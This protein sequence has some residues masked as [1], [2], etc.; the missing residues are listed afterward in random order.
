MVRQAVGPTLL[1]YSTRY[2][3]RSPAR[4]DR[5][6]H[7]EL[8]AVDIDAQQIEFGWHVV[9]SNHEIDVVGGYEL[10]ACMA[11][12]TRV[13]CCAWG[14]PRLVAQ[15]FVASAG[16][17]YDPYSPNLVPSSSFDAG[18]ALPSVERATKSNTPDQPECQESIKVLTYADA[19]LLT[20]R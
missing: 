16:T 3:S 7:P 5:V 6:S 20:Q 12:G 14:Q 9:L 13:V 1:L 10:R 8:V 11:A 19:D 15:C 17:K 2:D 18:T 4:T